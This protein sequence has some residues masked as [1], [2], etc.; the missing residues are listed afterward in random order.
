MN[1]IKNKTLA[2]NVKRT[3]SNLSFYTFYRWDNPGVQMSFQAELDFQGSE[4]PLNIVIQDLNK[5]I[6]WYYHRG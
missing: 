5:N 2:E 4:N 1:I 3:D 6:I